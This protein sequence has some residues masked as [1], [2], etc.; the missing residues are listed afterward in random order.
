MP[1]F[2]SFLTTIAVASTFVIYGVNVTFIT[3]FAMLF[4]IFLTLLLYAVFYKLYE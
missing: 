1:L 2:L 4:F 3:E